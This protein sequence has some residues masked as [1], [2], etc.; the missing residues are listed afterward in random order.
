MGGYDESIATP[1]EWG[2]EDTELQYRQTHHGVVILENPN[3]QA[4][5][6]YHPKAGYS[7]DR[8]EKIRKLADDPT[9]LF[10]NVDRPD[11]G[12]WTEKIVEVKL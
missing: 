9:H 3:I 8:F 5:H 1:G 6:C 11:W 12:K 7:D 10:A 2:G 4:V